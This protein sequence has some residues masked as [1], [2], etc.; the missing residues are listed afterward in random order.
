MLFSKSEELRE[1]LS[2]REQAPVFKQNNKGLWQDGSV[3]KSKGCSSRG[4][5][6]VAH[7]QIIGSNALFWRAVVHAEKHPH[8]SISKS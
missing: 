2:S 5:E 3:A 4:P 1:W 8:T 6:L 7:N